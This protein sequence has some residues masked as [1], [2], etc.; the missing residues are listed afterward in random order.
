M[1]T[2]QEMLTDSLR[3]MYDAERQAV[4]NMPKFARAAS[5]PELKQAINDHLEMTKGQVARLEQ[6]FEILGERAKPKPCKAMQGLVAEAIEHIGEH[7]KGHELDAVLIGAAQKI[8][9]YEIS[10]YGTA[11]A[12]AKAAGQ[13][14]AAGLL[15][16]TL[17]EEET[18]DKTLTKVALEVYKQMMSPEGSDEEAMPASRSAASKKKVATKAGNTSVQSNGKSK[19]GTKVT[20]DHDEIKSW[21]EGRGAHPACVKGTGDKG[22]IGLLRIDFPGYSGGDS[23]AE[24]TWEEFFQKF[25]EQGLALLYQESTARGQKSNFN[26]LVARET[27]QLVGAGSGTKRAR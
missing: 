6:V 23:L 5:S 22:D 21:A 12:M 26:K 19:A 15:Q 7:S 13:K 20:M 14:E 17:K 9:H 11:R 2:I 24:I 8:E 25:D 3:D 16:E 1:A 27:A 4:K 10:A 18:T